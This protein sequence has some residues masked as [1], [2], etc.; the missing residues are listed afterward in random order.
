VANVGKGV[1]N[2]LADLGSQ[3]GDRVTNFF[4]GGGSSGP[5]Q[6]S[7][8]EYVDEGFRR[9]DPIANAEQYLNAYNATFAGGV[10]MKDQYAAEIKSLGI[11]VKAKAAADYLTTMA[12]LK[13]L[14][15]QQARIVDK[16]VTNPGSLTA[17][18]MQV[19][20][21]V[22]STAPKLMADLKATLATVGK[23]AKVG[24]TGNLV[25]VA[26]GRMGP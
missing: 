9:M 4:T 5:R 15:E 7:R 19:Y 8:I 12:Q 16:L 20:Q 13:P 23:D 22:T 17:G 24:P 21:S 14:L 1:A 25:V 11:D 2:A 18:D 3:I 10:A 26:A 6:P